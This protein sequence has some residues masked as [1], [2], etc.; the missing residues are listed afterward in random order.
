MYLITE[1]TILM[2]CC[3]IFIGIVNRERIEGVARLER[4]FVALLNSFAGG[5]IISALLWEFSFSETSSHTRL[6]MPIGLLFGQIALYLIRTAQART[7]A[8]TDALIDRMNQ[9]IV[10]EN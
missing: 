6:V 5:S 2:A 9:A 7:Q 1:I 3:T 4:F 10:G 8:R